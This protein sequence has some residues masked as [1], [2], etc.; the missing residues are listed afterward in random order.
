M[1]SELPAATLRSCQKGD[2]A[3]DVYVGVCERYMSE[4][5]PADWDQSYQMEHK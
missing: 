3:A 2:R 5:P 1:A 4:P